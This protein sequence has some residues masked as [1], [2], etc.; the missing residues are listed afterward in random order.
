MTGAH[1][2]ATAFGDLVCLKPTSEA[3]PGIPVQAAGPHGFGTATQS[4]L[5]PTCLSI[6][7]SCQLPDR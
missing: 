3:P 6:R 1:H 2:A 7:V 5:S 4:K